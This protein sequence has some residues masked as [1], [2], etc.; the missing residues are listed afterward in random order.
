[1]K[2][3]TDT[4]TPDC[5]KKEKTSEWWQKRHRKKLDEIKGEK[6][7]AQIV[8]IGNSVTYHLEKLAVKKFGINI[9]GN[10]IRLIWVL[11]PTVLK[12]Y[13]GEL[14]KVES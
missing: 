8:F 12:M 6:L 14:P 3:Q 1:M 7:N 11:V 10:T 2:N 5:L 9:L 4:I 13:F